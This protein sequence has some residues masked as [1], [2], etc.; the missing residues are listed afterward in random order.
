MKMKTLSNVSA[1][2][3]TLLTSIVFSSQKSLGAA[4][5]TKVLKYEEPK[6][7]AGTIYSKDRKKVLFKFTRRSTR[8]GDRLEVTRDFSHPDGRPALKEKV[9]YQGD[10]LLE[11]DVDDLQTGA[12]GS[13]RILPWPA[14]S[15]KKIISFDYVK[16]VRAKTKPRTGTETLRNECLVSDMVAPFLLDHW[17][18]LVKGEEIKCRYVV[19]DRRETVGF[20]FV[21]DSETRHDGRE[22][23]IVKMS[24]SSAIISALVDPLFFT[25]E[26]NGRRRILEYSGR[27]PLKIREGNKWRD[28]EGVTVF[29]WE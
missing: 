1:L 2:I 5:E 13:A 16:D 17:T 20:T 29:E 3:L 18:G 22:V 10:E 8:N 25:I 26:K 27:T 19:V 12:R 6:Q 23:M 7:L 15:S 28:L 4:A 11:Y 24:P 9:I 21:K 14:Q